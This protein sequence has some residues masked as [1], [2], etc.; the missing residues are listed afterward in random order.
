MN[1]EKPDFYGFWNYELGRDSS[2][3][4]GKIIE[5]NGK[6][7]K[8]TL[9]DK[10]GEAEFFGALNDKKSFNFRKKYN[11]QAI[12]NGGS[13]VILNYNLIW[14][15]GVEDT[16]FYEGT[17]ENRRC[18]AGTCVIFPFTEESNALVSFYNIFLEKIKIS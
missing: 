7:L 6:K 17:W 5:Q 15:F 18:D 16:K 2:I 1:N 11:K 14:K 3:F 4:F 13:E 12:K 8:G 9:I 10:F